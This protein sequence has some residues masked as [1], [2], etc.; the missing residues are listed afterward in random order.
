MKNLY[1][2]IPALFLVHFSAISLPASPSNGDFAQIRS[3]LYIVS[4]NGA[5][6]L[7][8][9]NLTQYNI[10]YSNALDGMDARK[11][12]NPS[13]NWGMLR[14]NTVYVIERR[15]T[16]NGTDSIFFKMWNMRIITYRLEFITSNLNFP[17]RK[18]LLEDNYLKT[19]TPIDLNGNTYV[20]FSVTSDP[21]SKAS[22]RFRLIFSKSSEEGLLPFSFTFAN[23]L[24]KN[25]SVLINWE[26]VNAGDVKAFN[27]EKSIDG[28]HF[29]KTNTVKT[30]L[31]MNQYHYTDFNAP[32]GSNYYRVSTTS[33]EGK[34]AY[35][36]T[37]KVYV[38]RNPGFTI[39]PNPATS[40]NMNLQFINK[41]AG[42]YKVRLIN[43]FGQTFF[44]K[45]IQYI[46]GSSIEKI[47]PAQS[48]PP[49]VYQLEIKS[50]DE[51][52]TV[53]SVVF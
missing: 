10:D 4:T 52:R 18:G 15:H 47:Q 7:M 23:A 39:Y 20:D 2:L 22:D 24:Q 50:P 33:T 32:E 35:S 14:N 48:V 51:S 16:M 53:I 21:A 26:A 37:V 3:N 29:V 8:E 25:N 40:A 12:S 9:G 42:H 30:Q 17:G 49:G 11:M 36:E 5:T 6:T 1:I 31:N 43:S 27:I 46:G 44:S 45:D 41:P 38:T 34:V 19:S 13:E 28:I